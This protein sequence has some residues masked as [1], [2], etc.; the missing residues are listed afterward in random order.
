M[1]VE[2]VLPLRDI[3]LP[4]EPGI[5]PLAPGVW[6][7]GLLAL[8]LAA[9]MLHRG[10][11]WWRR[12]RRRRLADAAYAGVIA[13]WPPQLAPA[14]HLAAASELLRRLCRLHAPQALLLQG[15]AWLDFLD[16]RDASRPFSRGPG[17]I[18]LDGP[19]RVRLRPEEVIAVV[20]VLRKCAV[21]IAGEGHA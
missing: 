11:R 5:W 18:L 16:G 12:R 8:L 14:Q 10:V 21:R 4:P 7:L 2:T 20:P 17:R 1:S 13:S 19:Y 15:E 6:I 3:Q 9:G